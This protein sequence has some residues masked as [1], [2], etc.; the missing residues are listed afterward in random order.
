[1]VKDPL[2]PLFSLKQKNTIEEYRDK[3]E[4]AIATHGHLTEEVLKGAFLKGLK[5]DV[6]AELKLYSTRT[7]AEVMDVASLIENK[8]SEAL[9]VKNK[10]EERKT[11]QSY[12]KWGD[13]SRNSYN[14]ASTNQLMKNS[15]GSKKLEEGSSSV[16]MKTS[17]RLSQSELQ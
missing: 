2:G 11:G 12:P 5:R 9:I 1:M 16:S 13:G 17:P 10:E 7:L 15:D 14:L 3:F 6:K 4:T 8:N